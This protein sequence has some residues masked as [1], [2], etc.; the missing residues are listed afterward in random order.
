M[1]EAAARSGSSSGGCEPNAPRRERQVLGDG[2]VLPQAEALGDVA[3]SP[4]RLARGRRGRTAGPVPDVG[5]SRP[6][7]SRMRVVLPA[8]LAP[9]SPTTSPARTSRSTPATAA[10]APKRRTTCAATASRAC[11]GVRRRPP[12]RRGPLIRR[13]AR[14]VA[15]AQR[16]RGVAGATVLEQDDRRGA[17][18]LVEVGGGDDHRGSAGRGRGDHPPQVGAAHGVHARGGLVQDQQVGLVQHRQRE[19]ELLAHASREPAGEPGAGALEA[20]LLQQAPRPRVPLA[21]RSGRRRRPRTRCSRP[22]SGRRT[23]LTRRRRS[24]PGAS[25]AAARR[26]RPA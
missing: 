16:V 6:R 7:S 23:D 12:A 19:G 2:E 25:A 4:S 3:E 1:P 5:R 22:R 18:R 10:N 13:V 26:R 20:R 11:V 15:G 14:R 21:T 9:S 8:P 24:P 17:V